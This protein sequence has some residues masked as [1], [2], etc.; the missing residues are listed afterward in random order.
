MMHI[1]LIRYSISDVELYFICRAVYET[2]FRPRDLQTYDN[3][4]AT[5]GNDSSMLLKL[6]PNN[7]DVYTIFFIAQG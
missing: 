4:Q 3:S 2:N 5:Q 6:F 1:C 7:I